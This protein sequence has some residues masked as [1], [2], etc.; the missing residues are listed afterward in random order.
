MSS[1]ISKIL[2]GAKVYNWTRDPAVTEEE[3]ADDSTFYGVTSIGDVV[4][5]V[6][7]APSRSSSSAVGGVSGALGVAKGF[8]KKSLG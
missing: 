2:K 4:K 8:F 3:A 5:A 1:D 7:A 6:R